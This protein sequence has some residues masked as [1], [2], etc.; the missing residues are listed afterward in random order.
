MQKAKNNQDKLKEEKVKEF[1]LLGI[2]DYHKTVTIK[3]CD[4]STVIDK[5]TNGR[6]QSTETD[7]CVYRH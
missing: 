6:K 1:A 3:W 5:Q 4:Q 7:P 2:N